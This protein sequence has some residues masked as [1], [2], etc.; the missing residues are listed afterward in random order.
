MPL[1]P[2]PAST[3][4]F[5]FAF[6]SSLFYGT[7]DFLGGIAA[8]RARVLAVTLWSQ[9]AG[10]A[11]LA[12]VSLVVGGAPTAAAW[13][14]AVGAGIFGSSG[15][16][17]F[18]RAL[19]VG[20]VSIVAPVTSAVALCVPVAV[21]LASGER[22]GA[23]ALAGILLAAP[24]IMLVG[25]GDGKQQS[26]HA[27][28][29]MFLALVSG[30]LIGGFL[31]AIG[32]LPADGGLWP[33]TIARATGTLAIAAVAL[34]LRESPRVPA[35]AWWPILGCALLDVTANVFFRLAAGGAALSLVATV[36]SLAPASTVLLA[37]FLLHER[38]SHRQRA[39][40]VLAL[41]AIVLL[42]QPS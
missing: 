7:A 38:L 23:L 30:V 41:V 36:V 14:W 27:G 11:A 5:A 15:V 29:A 20:T 4:A 8:R 12:A 2:A 34:A 39:G 3:V 25:G 35:N 10:L 6:A 26:A 32:R 42:A 1:A 21:G 17:L 9:A 33:L 31:V 24:A 18:Y 19:A 37:R 16:L 22:P 40:V 13:P 28:R